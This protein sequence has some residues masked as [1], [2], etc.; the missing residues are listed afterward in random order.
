VG[1]LVYWSTYSLAGVI[2]KAPI[3]GGTI[4]DVAS[5]VGVNELAVGAADIWWTHDPD[6]IESVPVGGLPDGGTS[7]LLTGNPLSNGITSD[8]SSVYWVNRGDGYVRKSDF[9]LSNDTPLA[10][11]DVPWGIAVDATSV[12]WTEAGS[13]P[14][15]G[16]VM[17]ASKADG[18]GGVT[19]AM[20]QETPQGIAVDAT[21][22]YWANRA[23]DVCLADADC[24]S[25]LCDPSRKRCMGQGTINK[26]PLA[27]GAVTVLAHGQ[28]TPIKLAVDA[29]HVYWTNLDGDTVVKIAK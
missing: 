17:K 15:K 5:T 1:G 14:K 16:K 22:V 6:D 21:H 23:D 27:G 25:N 26:A 4:T 11:G 28:L 9:D 18:S 24:A 7:K 8:A 20:T 29:T 3:G 13:T 2:R 12:Y 19:I 10:N